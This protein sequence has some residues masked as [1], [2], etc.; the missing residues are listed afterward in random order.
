MFNKF[1]ETLVFQRLFL[2]VSSKY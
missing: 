2:K 1:H